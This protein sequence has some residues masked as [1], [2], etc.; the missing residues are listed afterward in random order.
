ML[1]CILRVSSDP[2][3]SYA[4]KQ[5]SPYYV[6]HGGWL[7]RILE[8]DPKRKKTIANFE[9]WSRHISIGYFNLEATVNYWYL[10]YG[11]PSRSIATSL[12]K[13]LP[14]LLHKQHSVGKKLEIISKTL[15][16][17]FL[18]IGNLMLKQVSKVS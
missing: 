15:F 10:W 1:I 8:Q 2:N 7:A 4:Q 13:I 14:K 5:L 18:D 16:V 17:N 9:K 12:S 3:S 11:A 6:G